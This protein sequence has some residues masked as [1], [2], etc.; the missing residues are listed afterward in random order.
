MSE[1][2]KDWLERSR[3]VVK[4][5]EAMNR[6][7]QTNFKIEVSVC[8]LEGIAVDWEREDKGESCGHNKTE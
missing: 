8:S 7:Q 3:K 1:D 6:K 2:N 5:A 4:K